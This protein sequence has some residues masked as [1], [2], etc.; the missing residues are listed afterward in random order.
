LAS[1]AT[2]W[3]MLINSAVTAG[4]ILLMEVCTIFIILAAA[5][6]MWRTTSRFEPKCQPAIVGK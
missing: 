1:T 2:N 3:T 4:L 5:A 6:K